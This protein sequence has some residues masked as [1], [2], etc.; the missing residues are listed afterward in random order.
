MAGSEETLSSK[1]TAREQLLHLASLQAQVQGKSLAQ[2]L[3]ELQSLAER[4]E[5]KASALQPV[6]PR[7]PREKY[8][9]LTRKEVELLFEQITDLRDRALFGCMYHFGLRASEVGILLREHVN[10]KTRRI[11]I[12]RLKGGI[13]GERVMTS[14][15]LCPI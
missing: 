2:Y 7:F 5:E 10:F 8:V 3:R 15:Q 14:D 13:P 12:P 11:Y 9:Y 1:G 4:K 6:A